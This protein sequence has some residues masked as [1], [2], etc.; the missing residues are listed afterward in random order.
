MA[1]PLAQICSEP[2]AKKAETPPVWAK[3]EKKMLG[4]FHGPNRSISA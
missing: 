3:T 4:V 1:Q 2:T